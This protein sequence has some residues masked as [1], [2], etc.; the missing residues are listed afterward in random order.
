MNTLTSNV[1]NLSP[2][3]RVILE[4]KLLARRQNSAPSPAEG[5]GN[6]VEHNS[7]EENR[8]LTESQDSVDGLLAKFYRRFPW[9]WQPM[10]FDY[11]EDTDFGINMLNQ[12]IGDFTH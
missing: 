7:D 8:V 3:Q 2:Q 12:D 10:K 4:Q 11:L 1:A 5:N 6:G 9:P